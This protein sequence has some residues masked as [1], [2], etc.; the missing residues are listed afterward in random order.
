MQN[1]EMINLGL[2]TLKGALKTDL[3][4]EAQ[5]AIVELSLI[6]GDIKAGLAALQEI[7]LSRPFGE[8]LLTFYVQFFKAYFLA[9]SG[10]EADASGA[11]DLFRACLNHARKWQLKL[12]ELHTAI[13]LAR[14]MARTGHREAARALL[15]DTYNWFTEGFDTVALQDAKAVLRDLSE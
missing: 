7:E 4:V 1:I 8:G 12:P 6:A 10:D 13:G 9:L 15:A 2:E 3:R 5:L 14:L 11:E